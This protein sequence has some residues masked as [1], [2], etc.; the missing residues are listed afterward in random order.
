MQFLSSLKHEE[1]KRFSVICPKHTGRKL[2]KEDFF[3]FFHT[4]F[5]REAAF[6][7]VGCF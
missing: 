2:E 4:L 1:M 6:Q 3:V 7:S 5:N